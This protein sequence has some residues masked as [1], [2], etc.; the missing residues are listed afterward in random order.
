MRAISPILLKPQILPWVKVCWWCKGFQVQPSLKNGSLPF[1]RLLL[2]VCFGS[3]VAPDYL[4][5]SVCFLQSCHS[6]HF[7]Q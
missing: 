1:R 5:L 2:S 7:D 6:K 4:D 3:V